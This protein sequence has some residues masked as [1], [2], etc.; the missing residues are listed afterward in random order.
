MFSYWYFIIIIITT[1]EVPR[2]LEWCPETKNWVS[3]MAF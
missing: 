2:F 3:R 1:P